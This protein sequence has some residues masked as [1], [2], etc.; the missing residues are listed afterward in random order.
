[1]VSLA[2]VTMSGINLHRQ[3]EKLIEVWNSEGCIRGPALG[4]A[5]GSVAAMYENNGILCH[6]LDAIQQEYLELMAENDNVHKSITV[7]S[8]LSARQ[9]KVELEL[10]VWTAGSRMQ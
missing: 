4:Q 3:L 6:F 9:P 1:M 5:D 2:S 7:S 10:Q 8:E